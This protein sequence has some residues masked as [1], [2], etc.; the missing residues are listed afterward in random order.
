M[1]TNIIEIFSSVQGEGKYVGCR[2]IFVRFEGCNLDCKYCDTEHAVGTHSFCHLETGADTEIYAKKMNPL[3]AAEVAAIIRSF[4]AETSHQ[5]V[6]FTGGEPLFHAAFIKE[7]REKLAAEGKI[8]PLFLLETNGTLY[9]ELYAA[10]DA[11][12]IISMDIKLPSMLGREYWEEHASFLKLAKTKDL[13]VKIVISD[14]TTEKEFQHAV[15]MLAKISPETLLILQPV[16]P[17]NNVLPMD[18][19]SLLKFQSYALR[20][21]QDVRVIAQTHRMLN[22]A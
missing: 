7:V 16:T 8:F 21:L 1:K 10:W 22:L 5:A 3:S 17:V 20:R 18:T 13:Y 2:Q 6:S 9:Q 12:D 4:C 19:K 11:V 15:D 14:A